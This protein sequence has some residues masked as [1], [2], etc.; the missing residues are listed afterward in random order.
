MPTFHKSSAAETTTRRA[1]HQDALT[2]LK[3]DHKAVK[4]LFKDYQKLVDAGASASERQ[5]LAEQICAMLN[6]HAT[7]EEELVYPP[8]REVLGDD[9][10]LIDEADVEHASAKD[11][12]AQIQSSTPGDPHFDAKVKVLGELIDHH[13]KEEEDEMLPK[14]KR[15]AMDLDTIG[16]MLAVRKEELEIGNAKAPAGGNRTQTPVDRKH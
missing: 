12:I 8:A 2:L 13:V 14:L 6:V 1:R 4:V 5:N 9:E 3:A 11:L 7:I 16:E 10:D 15:S